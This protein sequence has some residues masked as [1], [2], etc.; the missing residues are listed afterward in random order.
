[1]LS[2]ATLL[3]VPKRSAI[4]VELGSGFVPAD[5]RSMAWL[6]GEFGSRH[7]VSRCFNQDVCVDSGLGALVPLKATFPNSCFKE[8]AMERTRLVQLAEVPYSAGW[9]FHGTFFRA[10]SSLIL[11]RVAFLSMASQNPRSA[12]LHFCNVHFFPGCV[13]LTTESRR[14]WSRTMLVREIFVIDAI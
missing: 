11:C 3:V 8:G 12:Y 2:C 7:P 4:F 10:P 14:S 1:M 6:A 9:L 13:N 5:P